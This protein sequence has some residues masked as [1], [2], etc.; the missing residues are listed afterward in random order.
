MR[1]LDPTLNDILDSLNA[2]PEEKA[3]LVQFLENQAASA[4]GRVNGLNSS[5]ADLSRQRAE[6]VAELERI[7]SMLDKF[8][9]DA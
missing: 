9:D 8:T 4:M 5:I 2:T 3:V 1:I 6:A 7:T